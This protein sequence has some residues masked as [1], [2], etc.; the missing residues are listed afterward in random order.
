LKQL[1]KV[2]LQ[3]QRHLYVSALAITRNRAAAEDCVHEA[4]LAVATLRE[5]PRDMAAYLYRVVR[6]K[7]LHSLKQENRQ[8]ALG[9]TQDDY[10]EENPGDAEHTTL[11]QQIKTQIQTLAPDEQQVLILKLFEDLTFDEI[12]HIME[13]SPN[14]VASW[15]RRGLVKLKELLND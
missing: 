9:D 5:A 2:F 6:N 11:V 14:T 8:I 12:A 3:H 1:E 10:L 7:A 13:A 4:L 15:Y